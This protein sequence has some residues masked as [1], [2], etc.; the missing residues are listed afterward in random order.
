M[1]NNQSVTK[2]NSNDL[3]NAVAEGKHRY[4]LDQGIGALILLGLLVF[5]L[6]P[7]SAFIGGPLLALFIWLRRTAS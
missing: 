4:D 5:P 6:V 1:E 3:A 2:M 7:T